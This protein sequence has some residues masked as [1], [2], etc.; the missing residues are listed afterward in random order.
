MHKIVLT[1]A[2]GRDDAYRQDPPA[3]H[4]TSKP[5]RIGVVDD[6]KYDLGYNE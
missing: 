6:S 4:G 5:A 3:H 1:G 2:A